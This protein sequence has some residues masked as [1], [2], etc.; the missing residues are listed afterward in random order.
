MLVPDNDLEL[1]AAHPVRLG[2]E[3]VILRH[4]LGVLDDPPQLVHH[5]LDEGGSLDTSRQDR[6]TFATRTHI[7]DGSTPLCGS[8]CR[9]CSCCCW[10]TW[11]DKD[12]HYKLVDTSS[13][14]PQFAVG[15]ELELEELVAE[16]A[17]VANVVA[18]VE[19]V[20]H[21]RFNDLSLKIRLS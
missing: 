17:L 8:S 6:K 5:G 10:H 19:V 14:L 4:D 12:N 9:S 13:C 16:L 15:P 3:G 7:P 20:R 2:P 18:E 1:L 11:Q 21:P